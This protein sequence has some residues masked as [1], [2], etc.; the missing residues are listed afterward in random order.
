M[1][2]MDASVLGPL[3]LDEEAEQKVRPR[4]QEDELVAPELVDI[5]VTALLRKRHRAKLLTQKRASQALADLHDL[6]VKRIPHR[7]LLGRMWELR[8]N[9]TAYDAAYVAVAEL[10]DATVL[11]A[12]NRLANA[13]GPR[14][15]FEVLR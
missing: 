2:V 14:C 6:P 7:A 4:I 9:V 5:E 11:T 3:L 10:Y 12:D 13:S 1:I 15:R 8:D